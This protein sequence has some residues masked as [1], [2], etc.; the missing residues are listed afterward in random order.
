MN[1]VE[2]AEYTRKLN[3]AASEAAKRLINAHDVEYEDYLEQNMGALGYERNPN[4]TQ[5]NNQGWIRK[6][7]NG[8]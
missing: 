1:N 3:A 7:S 6:E 2:F 5:G 4:R 8:E